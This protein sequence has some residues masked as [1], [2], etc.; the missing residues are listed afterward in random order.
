M[1]EPKE[2]P[3]KKEVVVEISSDTELIDDTASQKFFGKEMKD[4][5]KEDLKVEDEA[6]VRTPMDSPSV[7]FFGESLEEFA[8]Q[9]EDE[10]DDEDDEDEED[11]T[12][13]ERES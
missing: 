3:E 7:Q 10:P 4:L 11:A 9:S 6:A 8:E 13:N 2:G 12:E 5:V 1:S